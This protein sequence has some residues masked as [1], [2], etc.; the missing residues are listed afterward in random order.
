MPISFNQI[1]S[2]LRLP[3]VYTEQDASRALKG[4]PQFNSVVYLLGQK[5]ST[6]TATADTPVLVTSV[7]QA[8][9]YFGR[10]SQLANMFETFKEN[11]RFI[12]TW[13]IPLADD[14]GGTQSTGDIDFAGSPTENGTIHLYIA[15]RHIPVGVTSGQTPTVIAAAVVAKIAENG[16]LPV[17]AAVNGSDD[18]QVD[19]TARHKGTVGNAID[20]RLNYLGAE[21]GQKTPAGLT[22]TLTAMNGGATDPDYQDAI[23]GL[24]DEDIE[25][26]V[27]GTDQ[28]AE[29]AKVESE[30]ED[31]WGPLRMHEGFA[32]AAK[33]DTVANLTTFGN[34]RNSEFLS[35]PGVYDYPT[36]YYE[37]AA[38]Y[39]AQISYAA[40]NDPARPFQ[41]LELKNV[42][43]PPVESRFTQEERNLL[44]YDG[45]ASLRIA[46]D[47]SVQIE[48]AITTY[49]TNAASAPDPAYLDTNTILTLAYLRKS[50]RVRLLLK[51]PRHK[52]VDNGTRIGAGQ[53]AVTP[54]D[55]RA[56]LIALFAQ[57]EQVGLVENMEQF[58]TELIVE[59]NISDQNR[60][61]VLMPPDLANQLRI[62]ALNFQFLL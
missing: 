60:I 16:D 48:R 49:Q 8:Q 38:A 25:Y 14:A 40:S 61:D 54:N 29:L 34:A 19:F 58:K 39:G 27:L 51:F 13:A 28:A 17:T 11:Q 1:P 18:T 44:L 4:L 35:V 31:R 20:I 23:D 22:Y 9:E 5:L 50:S 62:L 42:L 2:N 41:T 3:G 53:A 33:Q 15:G 7:Q 56:E 32:F 30:L 6:G 36:P 37:I 59:R 26:F 21:N 43:A 46:K 45:I 55:I 24:P 57:W 47:G 52:L 12:E 10:G